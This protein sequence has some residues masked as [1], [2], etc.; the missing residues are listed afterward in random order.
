MECRKISD[1]IM[2][3]MD[4]EISDVEAEKLHGHIKGCSSC[5]MEFE[6]LKSALHSVEE[7][8]ELDLSYGFETKVM[9]AIKVQQKE[10]SKLL[11]VGIVGLISLVCYIAAFFTLPLI[12]ESGIIDILTYYI[13]SGFA[14]AIEQFMRGLIATIIYVGKLFTLR[15]LLMNQYMGIVN[16]A[17]VVAMLNMVV[18]RSIKYQHD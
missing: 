1:L 9:Q 3:Y 5:N 2:K 7:L 10:K 12:K 8:P 11:G 17:L 18:F 13:S 16:I 4:K 15:E 6:V 14:Y